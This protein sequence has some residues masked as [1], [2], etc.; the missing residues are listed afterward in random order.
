MT[1]QPRD[2]GRFLSDLQT[3]SFAAA[4][5]ATAGSLTD[6]HRLTGQQLSVF[7]GERQYAVLATTRRDGRPHAAMS[8]YLWFDDAVW[9]PAMAG[10]VRTGNVGS[11]PYASVL[12]AEEEGPH[13]VMVLF[14]GEASTA[15]SPPEGLERV[16]A[17]KFGWAADWADTWIAVTPIKLFSY[18]GEASRFAIPTQERPMGEDRS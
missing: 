6:E 4:S 5:Q 9:L 2:D 11:T 10:A 13:H 14:E 16:W 3:R 12:V 15:A 8:A 7:L 18:A 1:V 17:D